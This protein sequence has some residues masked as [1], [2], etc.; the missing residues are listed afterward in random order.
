M[1]K[2][3]NQTQAKILKMLLKNPMTR[4]ELVNKSKI[5]RTTLYNNLEKLLEMNYIN[6]VKEKRIA[7][8]RPR[9]FWYIERNMLNIIKEKDFFLNS[10]FINQN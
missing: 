5:P 7:V 2:T 1:I 3:L 8:G 6:R 4:Y 10:K 9:V